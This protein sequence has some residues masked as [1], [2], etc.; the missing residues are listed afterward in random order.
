MIS[1]EKLQFF[2]VLCNVLYIRWLCLNVRLCVWFENAKHGLLYAKSIAFM[3]QN[4]TNHGTN[5]LL[6]VCKTDDLL[7]I[8]CRFCERKLMKWDFS[9]CQINIRLK[10]VFQITENSVHNY[11]PC[12]PCEKAQKKSAVRKLRAADSCLFYH[13]F[14]A[15]VRRL[16]IFPRAGSKALGLSVFLVVVGVER[17]VYRVVK[18]AALL[19]L[20]CLTRNQVAHVDHVA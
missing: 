3:M 6:S 1:D 2:N 11:P 13:Q 14:Q 7:A 20:Y 15:C 10:S 17:I 18:S 8:L 4:G 19:A 5:S 16:G 12:L 9:R